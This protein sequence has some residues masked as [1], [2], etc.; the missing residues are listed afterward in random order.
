MQNPRLEAS[1]AQIEAALG[2]PP[3]ERQ[4]KGV[5]QENPLAQ[6]LA[7]QVGASVDGEGAAAVEDDELLAA[8]SRWG[9][10]QGD[11]A[12]RQRALPWATR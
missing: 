5:L 12:R 3:A 9:C 4:D 7:Q 6:V 1:V 2:P 10:A 11:P 8:R